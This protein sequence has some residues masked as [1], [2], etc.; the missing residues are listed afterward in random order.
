MIFDNK[1]PN[2][3]QADEPPEEY[4]R[5]ERYSNKPKI[6]IIS[7]FKGQEESNFQYSLNLTPGQRLELHYLM[8]TNL[9]K[10]QLSKPEPEKFSSI[11]IAQSP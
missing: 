4:L 11:V 3:W 10:E 8:I 7:S 9:Y 6:I 1:E 5:S 2:D